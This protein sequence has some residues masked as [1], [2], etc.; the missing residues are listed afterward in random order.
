VS[1]ESESA[2]DIRTY[3]IPYAY[4]ED[5]DNRPN[6]LDLDA[7]GDGIL[8]RTEGKGDPDGDS[9]PSFLDLDSDGDGRACDSKNDLRMY[10]EMFHVCMWSWFSFCP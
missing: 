7:D 2:D 1:D 8:D 10:P 4:F 5:G 3:L 6:Y 9:V